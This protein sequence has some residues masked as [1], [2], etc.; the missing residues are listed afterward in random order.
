MPIT[1]TGSSASEL[2]IR[3]RVA[4]AAAE[5]LS[6]G[7]FQSGSAHCTGWWVMSPVISARSPCDAISTETWP[8][9]CPAVGTS[10]TRVAELVIG[11]HE[12]GQTRFDDRPHRDVDRGR[13]DLGTARGG[14]VLPLRA[15]EQIPRI[16]ERGHDAIAFPHH[17]P[18][19]VIEVQVGT[20]HDVDRLARVAR[21]R[22][23]GEKVLGAV[24][25]ILEPRDRMRAEAGVDQDPQLPGVDHE[26][27]DRELD[28]ALGVEEVR[29]EPAAVRCE[30]RGGRFGE[31][32]AERRAPP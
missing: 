14:P 8:G 28:P 24:A 10:R 2:A 21:G 31:E 7:I 25:Q 6:A 12:V 18:A 26:A 9:V 29:L 30:R 11:L 22:E 3:R 19:D 5:S 15:R 1:S 17:V 4:A 32:L 20:Q 27:V 23:P 16:R 13:V